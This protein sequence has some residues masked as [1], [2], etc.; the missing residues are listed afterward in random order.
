VEGETAKDAIKNHMELLR[1][2]ANSDKKLA[3]IIDGFEHT[4]RS[5]CNIDGEMMEF[6]FSDYER[7]MVRKHNIFVCCIYQKPLSYNWWLMGEG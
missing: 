7:E 5:Y 4:K 2:A 3:K 6:D 1:E